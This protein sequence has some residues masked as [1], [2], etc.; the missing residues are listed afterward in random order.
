MPSA[1]RVENENYNIIFCEV[2]MEAS[3]GAAETGVATGAFSPVCMRQRDNAR[4]EL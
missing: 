1:E 2:E 3:E 4:L